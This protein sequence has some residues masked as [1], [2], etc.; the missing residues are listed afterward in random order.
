[1]KI[2]SVG[3]ELFHADRR[4][5]KPKPTVVFRNFCEYPRVRPSA[6]KL[7]KN[8]IIQIWKIWCNILRRR[9]R[10]LRLSVIFRPIKNFA[11][12]QRKGRQ[13]QTRGFLM[14][15]EEPD[16]KSGRK[17]KFPLSVFICGEMGY[18]L[19]NMIHFVTTSCCSSPLPFTKPLKPPYFTPHRHTLH[20]TP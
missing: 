18:T 7:T 17:P 16:M 15:E 12:Q 9:E 5:N 6:W 10:P 11:Q 14:K 13:R 19:L 2:R 4:T 20:K 3:A 1:M 8:F